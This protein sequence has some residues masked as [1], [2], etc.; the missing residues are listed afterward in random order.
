MTPSFVGRRLLMPSHHF[1][2]NRRFRRVRAGGVSLRQARNCVAC[3]AFVAMAVLSGCDDKSS[4]VIDGD[5]SNPGTG[6]LNGGSGAEQSGGT[7]TGGTLSA[8]TVGSSGGSAGSHVVDSGTDAK[9]DSAVPSPPKRLLTFVSRF[10][11]VPEDISMKWPGVTDANDW[12]RSLVDGAPAWS[13]VLEQL[14]TWKANLVVID[15]LALQVAAAHRIAFP[16]SGDINYVAAF[17]AL[18]G[19]VPQDLKSPALN[20]SLDYEIGSANHSVSGLPLVSIGDTSGDVT[21]DEKGAILRGKAPDEVFQKLF[22]FPGCTPGSSPTRIPV[23][24]PG[25]FVDQVIPIV[26]EAFRCDRTRT[27]TLSVPVPQTQEFTFD[28]Q[29]CVYPDGPSEC[30]LKYQL[31][32]SKQF[33]RIVAALAAVPENGGTLLDNTVVVWLSSMAGRQ[34]SIYPWYSVI[35]AGRNTGVRTGRYLHYGQ[36]IST[37]YR[38]PPVLIG[39]A[40]NHLLV[41]LARVFGLNVNYF[42][43]KSAALG[44]GLIVDTTGPLPR[45]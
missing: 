10:G 18:T 12:E 42:G 32:L 33:A 19:G 23:G 29:G 4:L 5:S 27:I 3:C 9:T 35:V 25:K 15:G 45:F 34:L 22:P 1:F 38:S 28:V 43:A 40:H 2:A 17:A 8:G 11:F 41:S 20:S 16:T 44:N 37:T 13:P 7:N 36:N 6:G 39:P 26:A 30:F 14:V 31:L 21:F 24:D